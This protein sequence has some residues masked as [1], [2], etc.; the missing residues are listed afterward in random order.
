M[1][2]GARAAGAEA[3]AGYRRIREALQR[4]YEEER[5]NIVVAGVQET[6]DDI[7]RRNV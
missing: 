2:T 4:R 1:N 3:H 5:E 6:V 7:G